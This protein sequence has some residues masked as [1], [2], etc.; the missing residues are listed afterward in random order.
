MRQ[1]EERSPKTGKQTTHMNQALSQ[2]NGHSPRYR[3]QSIEVSESMMSVSVP[4]IKSESYGESK[5]LL[6]VGS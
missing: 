1:T 4:L 5:E 2:A 6:A 3:E